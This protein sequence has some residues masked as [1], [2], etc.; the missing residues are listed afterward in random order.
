MWSIDKSRQSGHAPE[1]YFASRRSGTLRP[2]ASRDGSRRAGFTLLEAVVSLAIISIVAVATLAEV[3]AQLRAMDHAQHTT[4]AAMLAQDRL[5]AVQLFG[6]MDLPSL[7]DSLTAGRF[8][9]PLNLYTWQAMVE[10]IS[11]V[12][13]LNTVSVQINWPGGAYTLSSRLYHAP[14]PTTG[15][16]TPQNNAG[17]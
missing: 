17:G 4:E 14:P 7:P 10:P 15:D 1:A 16:S 3:G 11:Q 6:A 13:G 8:P 9:P 12:E 5:V 2:R